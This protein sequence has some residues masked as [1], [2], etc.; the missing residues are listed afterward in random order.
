MIEFIILG[1]MGSGEQSQLDVALAMKEKIKDKKIFI[2]GLG[3]NIYEC[4]VSSVDDEQFQ[5][6]FEIPYKD[7]NVPFYMCLGNH[8]Y[9]YSNKC[10]VPKENAFNQI[11]YSRFSDKWFLPHNYYTFDEK[12]ENTSISFFVFDTNLDMMSDEEIEKQKKEMIKNIKKSDSE[13]KIAYG[14]HTLR[15]IGGHGNAEDNFENFMQEI[16][17]EAPFDV[18]MCGHDH[19]KQ[20]IQMKMDNN[21]PLTL[22]VCGTGGKTYHKETFLKKLDRKC[23]LECCSNNLGYGYVKVFKV[24][25]K[26]KEIKTMKIELLD[27]K[28]N[29]EY[30]YTIKKSN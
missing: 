15:S 27:E 22:I 24:F 4:G 9:G 18:Y 25:E 12:D 7:I 20:V 30:I 21:N 3:D 13:W 14:H 17:R 23:K 28:N 19:N 8:D 1:D 11:K 26:D 10:L 5:T 29:S 2:C 6:K 16:F